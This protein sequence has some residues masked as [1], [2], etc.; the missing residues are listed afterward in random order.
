MYRRTPRR[1][2]LVSRWPLCPGPGNC[3]ARNR[4]RPPARR[5]HCKW[6]D[7]K[8]PSLTRRRQASEL[9]IKS[10]MI[11][12]IVRAART[13]EAGPVC[14]RAIRH[15]RGPLVRVDLCRNAVASQIVEGRCVLTEAPVGNLSPS[16]GKPPFAS[17]HFP[18]FQATFHHLVEANFEIVPRKP[19]LVQAE[20]SRHG[21]HQR[22]SFH[23]R[24]GFRREL[25]SRLREYAPKRRPT[26]LGLKPAAKTYRCR[27]FRVV[28]PC[29]QRMRHP[30]SFGQFSGHVRSPFAPVARLD[31]TSEAQH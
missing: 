2:P 27:D 26:S 5:R 20:T 18:A 8:R 11:G 1:P 10:R 12:W 6:R 30:I 15:A 17:L 31:R 21:P 3:Q 16:A 13:G 9:G 25:R 22:R 28:R 24:R 7:G 29:L 4:L 23:R 19:A 14:N